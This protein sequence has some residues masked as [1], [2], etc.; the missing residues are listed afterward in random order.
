MLTIKK[1]R[2]YTKAYLF[3]LIDG[4]VLA[5]GIICATPNTTPT[6]PPNIIAITTVRIISFLPY[7]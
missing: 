7:K 4:V 6:A 3:T 1:V 2:F 5:S